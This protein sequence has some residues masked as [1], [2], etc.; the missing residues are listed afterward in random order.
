MN[1][2]KNKGEMNMVEKISKEKVSERIDLPKNI[3]EGVT[4]DEMTRDELLSFC[5]WIG[6][7]FE[8]IKEKR[9]KSDAKYEHNY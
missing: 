9:D 5:H 3:R 1:E 8:E 6:D 4:F 7:K 2:K